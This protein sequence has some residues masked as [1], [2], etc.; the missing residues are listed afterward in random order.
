MLILFVILDVDSTE[1]TI[2]NCIK[3]C[4]DVGI[5]PSII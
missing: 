2:L 3:V 1:D 5:K 4:K